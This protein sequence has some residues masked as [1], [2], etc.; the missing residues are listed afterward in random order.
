MMVR[1]RGV[2][3]DSWEG[4]SGCVGDMGSVGFWIDE[5]DV[6]KDVEI[7]ADGI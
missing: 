4:L 5:G 3:G 7:L 2:G 6:R 1:E